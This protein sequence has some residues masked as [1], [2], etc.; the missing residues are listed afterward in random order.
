MKKPVISAALGNRYDTRFLINGEL[1]LADFDLAFPD[2]GEHPWISFHRMVTTLPW[3]IGEQAFSHYVIARDQGVPLTAIPVFPSRF[4]PQLGAVVSRESGITTAKDLEGKKVGVMGFGYNPAVWM[5]KILN[6][7]YQV[8]TT[9]IIWVEDEEDKF[10]GGIKYPKPKR[11]QIETMPFDSLVQAGSNPGP[12]S[13]LESGQV[14]AFFAPAGGPPTNAKTKRLFDNTEQEINKWLKETNVLPINTVITLRQS[15]VEQHPELAQQLFDS[16][17]LAR[18]MYHAG[19]DVQHTNHL[20]I[21]YT[22]L[23]NQGLFPDQYGIKQNHLAIQMM[24]DAC[25]EQGITKKRY[26]PEELFLTVS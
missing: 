4:F 16:L 19:E 5:R 26:L 10:L 21:E 17:K 14:D 18:T 22:Y 6:D 20:G 7:L 13:A 12:V 3:D 1:T 15:S 9:K 24:L 23:S 2:A 11:Y 25:Y 8:D